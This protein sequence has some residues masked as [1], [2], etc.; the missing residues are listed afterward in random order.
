MAQAKAPDRRVARTRRSLAGALVSLS[1]EF[2]YDRVS[3][4]ELTER[5][6]VGY[7]TFYRHFR[8][9]DELATYCLLAVIPEMICKVQSAETLHE[10]SL[11]VFT[12]LDKHRDTCLFGLS[13]PRDHPV[14]KPF[15]EKITHWMV[16][17]YSAR[18]EAAIPL[19]VS[20][21]HI[22]NS[23]MELLRWW[24]TD[25]QDYSIEQM[26]IMHSELVVKVTETVA[27][28]RQSKS[29]PDIASD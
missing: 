24:L 18:N 7:A 4:R 11:A 29:L 20:V 2:G 17:L 27:L 10:E 25:G 6:D 26:A 8:S 12:V 9:K 13:L 19:E 3:I 16:T 21:N 15:W 28:D 23:A 1:L 22:I 14:L 5:A